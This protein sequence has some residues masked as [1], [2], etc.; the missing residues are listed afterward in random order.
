MPQDSSKLT[1]NKVYEDTK[2]GVKE[3][4]GGIKELATKLEGPAKHVYHTYI[5]QYRIEGIA[6]ALIY[7]VVIVALSI[8]VIMSFKRGIWKEG[9]TKNFW[10]VGQIVLSILLSVTVFALMLSITTV[11][12]MILNP[13]YYAIQD[14]IKA[15]K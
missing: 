15:F 13:E 9:D 7:L 1:V 8:L 12:G 2:A 11:L 6:D 14:I 10:A 4:I 5:R 3:A